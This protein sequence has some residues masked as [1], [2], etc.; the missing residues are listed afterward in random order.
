MHGSQCT[1]FLRNL[2]AI[3][4]LALLLFALPWSLSHLSFSDT[5]R[6]HARTYIEGLQTLIAEYYAPMRSDE[7][8]KKLKLSQDMLVG[9]FANVESI[10]SLHTSTCGVNMERKRELTD[11]RKTRE[12]TDRPRIIAL[13][14]AHQCLHAR[15]L[16]HDDT[17]RTTQRVE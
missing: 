11:A 15:Y 7:M 6:S 17:A 5:C 9:L 14:C 8:K 10:Y 1:M 2:L 12:G 13:F 4:C 16:S 3:V